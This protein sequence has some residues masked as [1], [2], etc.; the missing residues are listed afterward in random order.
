VATREELCYVGSFR[1]KIM[2]PYVQVE[3]EKDSKGR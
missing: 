1:K 2:L 3:K